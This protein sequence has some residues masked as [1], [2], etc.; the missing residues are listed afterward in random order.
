MY[1][2]S[3]HNV[4]SLELSVFLLSGCECG[5]NCNATSLLEYLSQ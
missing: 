4:G 2:F 1:I 5:E 3:V